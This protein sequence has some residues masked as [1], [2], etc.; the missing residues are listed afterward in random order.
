MDIVL[1]AAGE[2]LQSCTPA[3]FLD[4]AQVDLESSGDAN[5]HF[6]VASG[7]DF[8]DAWKFGEAIHDFGGGLTNDEDIQIS[9]GFFAASVASGEIESLD[10]L[11]LREVSCESLGET[12]GIIDAQAFGGLGDDIDI[13]QN[14]LL[15]FG[16]EPFKIRD[17]TLQA[18]LFQGSEVHHTEFLVEFHCFLGP[19]AGDFHHIAERCWNFL[20][21]F[22]QGWDRTGLDS[23]FRF[24]GERRADAIDRGE[25]KAL[26]DE[27]L[28]ALRESLDGRSAAAIGSD[29]EGVFAR[30][31]EQ[32]RQ[33]FEEGG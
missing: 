15:G 7:E 4:D 29:S 6:R 31:F 10:G 1:F 12:I 17:A 20:A 11:A 16:S 26:G 5:A 21:E 22:F 23:D 27:F 8:S 3:G 32:I 2:V 18:G 30:E 24:L 28:D 19:Q 33:F 9:D 14:A 25:V 13:L